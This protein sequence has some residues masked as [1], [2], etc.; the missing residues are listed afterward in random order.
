MSERA[1]WGAAAHTLLA[2]HLLAATS[3]AQAQNGALAHIASYSPNTVRVEAGGRTGF[4]FIVGLRGR[5]VL[6]AT[7]FHT[8]DHSDGDGPHVCFAAAGTPSCMNG[9]RI[10]V[11]DAVGDLPALD[12]AIL[13]VPYPDGLAWRADA[14]PLERPD[15]G[16]PVWFIGRAREWYIPGEPGRFVEYQDA[17][18]LVR[19]AG[20]GVAGGVSGAPILTAAG[21]IA[22]HVQSEGDGGDGY[23]VAIEAI[24]TRVER[25]AGGT[26]LLVPVADCSV[27]AAER[28]ALAGRTVAVHIDPARVAPALDAMARLH[29]AGARALLRPHWEGAWP[30]NEVSYPPGEL[31]TAR[32]VQALLAGVTRLEAR[33]GEKD[34]LEVWV[35]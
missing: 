17:Q 4:G 18:G 13:A 33:L 28:E 31:R 5:H 34:Q 16:A 2:V 22:M 30:R 10:H 6:I 19:Y 3:A 14:L 23:G 26:W 8:L 7:A 21:M 12:L 11:A 25:F 15:S 29:C 1:R 32:A 9:E 35:R 24:R 27:N 20:L